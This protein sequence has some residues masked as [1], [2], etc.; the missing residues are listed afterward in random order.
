MAS[1]GSLDRKAIAWQ[2]ETATG[3]TGSIFSRRGRRIR[4]VGHPE[5]RS[6]ATIAHRQPRPPGEM[7]Q[8]LNGG[9]RSDVASTRTYNPRNQPDHAFIRAN[10][11]EA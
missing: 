2:H 7:P 3:R 5:N 10:L 9:F 4:L 11:W 1:Q 6:P 8:A